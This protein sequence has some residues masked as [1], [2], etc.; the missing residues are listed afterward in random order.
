MCRE[1]NGL[2][3]IIVGKVMPTQNDRSMFFLIDRLQSVT[4]VCVN[5]TQNSHR[6][7]RKGMIR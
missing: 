6:R 2:R 1:I 4:G 5:K 7:P 3:N